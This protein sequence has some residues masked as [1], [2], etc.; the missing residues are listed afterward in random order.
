MM[1][2]GRIID[3]I[4]KAEKDRLTVDDLLQKFADLRKTERLTD[5]MIEQLRREYA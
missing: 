3:D 2:K 5:E 1:H 4:S